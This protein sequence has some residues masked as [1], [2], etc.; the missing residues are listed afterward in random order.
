MH[1]DL[2]GG[3]RVVGHER[4]AAVRRGLL[5]DVHG[6]GK[7]GVAGGRAAARER[8]IKREVVDVGVGVRRCVG[9]GIGEAVCG[10]G[11]VAQTRRRVE[12]LVGREA[13]LGLQDHRVP[14]LEIGCAVSG[15][16]TGDLVHDV[17]AGIDVGG[18]C[19]VEGLGDCE[20]GFGGLEEGLRVLSD[21]RT[22]L[23]FWTQ[24]RGQMNIPG[25]GERMAGRKERSALR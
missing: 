23:F 17:G 13:E 19:C 5:E 8:D 11:R 15:E 9:D 20:D 18:A 2:L 14:R 1:I 22:F 12:R 7:T 25:E 24:K 3:E 16:V 6:V 10:G 4:R 21:V